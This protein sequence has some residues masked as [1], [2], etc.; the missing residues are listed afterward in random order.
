MHKPHGC[1]KK[2]KPMD[3][4]MQAISDGLIVTV[5]GVLVV[6]I[7][8]TIMIYAMNIT[9]AAVIYLNK[10]FPPK[11]QEVPA[12]KKSTQTNEEEMI[13]AAIASVLNMQRSAK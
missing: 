2:E 1:Q 6:F 11:V 13:A 4:I 3:N 5:V 10:K 8:L 9:S 12:A 7:F